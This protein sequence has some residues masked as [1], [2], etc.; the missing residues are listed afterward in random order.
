VLG[1][2]L[3]THPLEATEVQVDGAGTDRITAGHRHPGP[4]EASQ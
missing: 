4:A 3:G 2:E 1:C